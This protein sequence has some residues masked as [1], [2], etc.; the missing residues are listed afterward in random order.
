MPTP[1]SE[2]RSWLSRTGAAVS[3]ANPTRFLA[4][5]QGSPDETMANRVADNRIE[6]RRTAGP[7]GRW[8]PRL[9]VAAV[10][11]TSVALSLEGSAVRFLTTNR[12]RVAGWSTIPL[13]DRAASSGQI[14]DPLALGAAIDAAFED[15]QLSRQ[16]VSWALPGFGV[17]T[18]LIELPNLRPRELEEA[19]REDFD[20]VLG[21]SLDDNYLF[22]ERLTGRIRQR[23]VFALAVPKSGVLAALEA[24]EVANIK[25]RT[26]D[27]RPLALARA[28]GRGDAIVTNLEDGSLD[29]VIIDRGV[30]A[31]MRSI[32]IPGSSVAREVAQNR[33]IEETE[34]ALAYY[35]DANPDHPLDVDTP[36]YLTGSWATGNALAEKIH[37]VTRHPIGRFKPDGIYP[38]ELPLTEYAVNLGLSLK[39]V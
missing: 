4:R 3:S 28:A 19:V 22:W 9:P 5:P 13:I 33:L 30:P 7:V 37:T 38:P 15:F 39:R 27:L 6:D 34:R 35:D 1:L 24:L 14:N 8:R 11:R 20:R 2:L 23:L 26:M 31:A 32:S 25:P 29:V 21:V 17:T 16:R 18:R 12:E 10:D 36:I